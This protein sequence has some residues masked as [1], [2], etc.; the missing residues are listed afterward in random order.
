MRGR[1]C[2]DP[3]QYMTFIYWGVQLQ[4]AGRVVLSPTPEVGSGFPNFNQGFAACLI[5]TRCRVPGQEMV[6]G[7]EDGVDRRQPTVQHAGKAQSST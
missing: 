6:Q 2:S 1:G 7:R 4:Q 5:F 3:F